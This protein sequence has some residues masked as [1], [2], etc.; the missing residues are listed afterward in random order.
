[1]LLSP[2]DQRKNALINKLDAV[3]QLINIAE[4]EEAATKLEDDILSKMDG[5]NGGKSKNDWVIEE[6]AQ[7]EIY[8]LVV[9]LI[10]LLHT[11]LPKDDSNSKEDLILKTDIKMR[12]E[13]KRTIIR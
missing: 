9:E 12:M 6:E 8:S 5:F 10:D 4:Y 11:Y 7:K 13:L 3:G 2:A 1:M